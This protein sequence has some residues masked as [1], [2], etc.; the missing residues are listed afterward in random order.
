MRRMIWAVVAILSPL[1]LLGSPDIDLEVP[2]GTPLD[3]DRELHQPTPVISTGTPGKAVA[4]EPQSVPGK[5]HTGI[6]TVTPQPTPPPTMGFTVPNLYNFFRIT[7]VDIM[8]HFQPNPGK[9]QPTPWEP[10]AEPPAA[11][12]PPK[13][14]TGGKPGV[15]P[16]FEAAPS[17]T[18]RHGV[19]GAYPPHVPGELAWMSIA[20]GIRVTVHPEIV[21]KPEAVAY[22]LELGEVAAMNDPYGLVKGRVAE[23]PQRA[24]GFPSMNTPQ[25]KMLSKIVVM[26]IC[27]GFPYSMDPTYAKKTL[28]MG[29]LSL[30][31]IVECAKQTSHTLLSHN[32]VAIL[33]NFQ[34]QKAADELLKLLETSGD[35]VIKVRAAAGLARKRYKKAIPALLNLIGSEE[36][37]AAMAIY[38][39]GQIAAAADDK[40][41][42]RVAQKL[43]SAA[44][45]NSPDMQWCLLAAVARIGADD[46]QT[47]D[48]VRR[49]REGIRA[50][51]AAPAGGPQQPP[52]NAPGRVVKPDAVGEKNKIL[53]QVGLLAA[54]ASGDAAAVAEASGRGLSAWHK[55]IHILVAE[56]LPNLGAQGRATAQGLV[57]AEDYNVAV[58]AIRSLSR[59]KECSDWLKSIASSGPRSVI[60]AAALCGLIG[61]DE[62]AT[63][64]ICKPILSSYSA[65][66]T[67]EDAFLVSLA[68]Q[69]MDRMGKNDGATILK[70][71][72]TARGANHVASRSATDEYD[73]T[74]AKISVFPAVLEV[75]VLALGKTRH[76][77]GLDELISLAQPG[78]PARGESVLSLGSYGTPEHLAR[79]GEALLRA[80]VEPSDGFVRFCAYL[81]LKNISGKDYNADYI[82]GQIGDVWPQAVKYRD[83]LVG[84]LPKSK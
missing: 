21:N 3:W 26:E 66:T 65:S 80:L 16:K 52:S 75:A 9:T 39:L 20:T 1:A 2:A 22:L 7:T 72:Q 35:P 12:E 41:K 73:V 84:A 74:K 56:V 61:H 54:A 31:S 40:E 10:V 42:I 55:S 69:M 47:L 24:P 64:E 43:A 79:A 36:G 51:P 48:A 71:V 60:R 58:A 29:D 33:A 44:A 8:N 68:V 5:G 25:D 23:L 53:D 76:P 37:V 78:S 17:V 15:K 45:A 83:W 67:A 81:S 59:F 82:F 77:E 28:M 38:A 27:S 13:I 18:L 30:L 4:K 57:G 70:I 46:K 32:A 34:G 14:E 6:Q 62:K 19:R 11:P 63:E 50:R 49:A